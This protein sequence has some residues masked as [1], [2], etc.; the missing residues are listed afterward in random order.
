LFH[1]VQDFTTG[2]FSKSGGLRGLPRTVAAEF[3]AHLWGGPA[4]GVVGTPIV[5]YGL[6]RATRV[7]FNEN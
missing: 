7:I 1:A 4:I 3:S 5:V 2:L 6:F